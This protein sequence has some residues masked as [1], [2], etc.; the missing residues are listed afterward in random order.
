M[1]FGFGMGMSLGRM[2]AAIAIDPPVITSSATFNAAENQTAVGTVTATGQAPITFSI[3]GGADA[4][5]FAINSGTGVLTFL[6]APDFETPQDAGANNVYNLTVTATNAGG[7]TNQN[8]A[9]TVTDVAEAPA[10]FIAH[11]KFNTG[12]TVTGAGVSQWDDNSGN[13]YHLV[14]ATDARRPA[15]ETGGEI[16]F[17]GTSHF[18]RAVMT[19][20]Q[21]LTVCILFKQITWTNNDRVFNN[22]S[23]STASM[24]LIQN[25]TTP[26]LRLYAG[27]AF[28]ADSTTVPLDTYKSVVCVFN[29]ASSLIHVAGETATTGNPGT[30]GIDG[31][32]TLGAEP[33]PFSWSNIQVKDVII[34]PSA[35]DATARGLVHTYHGTL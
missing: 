10:G 6:A 20:A 4:A 1:A 34:Y 28:V 23:T 19:Q 13:A 30:N 8:V 24:T 9:V 11:Y 22:N 15:K 2:M 12:I 26:L 27:S 18:L 17:N 31:A 21:P 33:F 16:T 3:T 25:G 7:A 29:G 32:F 35:L 14:Q 5:F